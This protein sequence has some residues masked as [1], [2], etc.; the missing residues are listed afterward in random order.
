M[1]LVVLKVFLVAL[2]A[3]GLA[4]LVVAGVRRSRANRGDPRW[5]RRASGQPGYEASL[6]GNMPA[7]PLPEWI[8]LDDDNTGPGS[9]PPGE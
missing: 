8:D 4:I 6:R 3:L 9:G 7:T 1:W 5:T 2:P